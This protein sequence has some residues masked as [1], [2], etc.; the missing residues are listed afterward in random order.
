MALRPKDE[1]ILRSLI[2]AANNLEDRHIALDKRVRSLESVVKRKSH[3]SLVKKLDQLEAM[4]QD[5]Q[6]DCGAMETA[7]TALSFET[8]GLGELTIKVTDKMRHL[9]LLLLEGE[10]SRAA[11]K[12]PRSTL[13]PI[14]KANGGQVAHR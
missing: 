3:P 4:L 14:A 7:V 8:F 2:T 5:V 12:Q 6:L 13:V 1:Q 9:A 11:T 10:G